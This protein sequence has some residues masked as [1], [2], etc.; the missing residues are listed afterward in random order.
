MH[1]SEFNAFSHLIINSQ[2]GGDH[3]AGGVVDDFCQ[4]HHGETHEQPHQAAHTGDGVND[5]GVLV[6]PDDLG[7]RGAEEA[8]NQRRVLLGIGHQ[9]AFEF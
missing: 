6:D 9:Q 7:E 8:G 2:N 1:K 3:E 5:G 4:C